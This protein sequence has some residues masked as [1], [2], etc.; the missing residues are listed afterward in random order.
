[1]P[2]V[3]TVKTRLAAPAACLAAIL[4]LAGCQTPPPPVPPP[5]PTPP[6]IALSGAVVQSAADYQAYMDDVAAIK[7]D[8][9][10]GEDVAQSL[11]LGDDYDP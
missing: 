4:V 8:F 3:L 1:M 5:P 10:S 11:K 6:P 7:A 2:S 9:K